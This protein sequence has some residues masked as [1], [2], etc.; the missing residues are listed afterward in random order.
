M[1]FDAP[2][3]SSMTIRILFDE[4]PEWQVPQ[5]LTIDP[6]NSPDASNSLTIVYQGNNSVPE[7]RL[8]AAHLKDDGFDI[9]IHR[10]EPVAIGDCWRVEFVLSITI[11]GAALREELIDLELVGNLSLRHNRTVL[12]KQNVSESVS[13]R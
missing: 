10:C 8:A 4:R 6:L 2:Y 11:V 9:S 13:T 7:V 1:T 12:M 3:L 5:V